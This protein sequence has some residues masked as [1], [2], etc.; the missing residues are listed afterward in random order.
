MRANRTLPYV[1][2]VHGIEGFA[3]QCGWIPNTSSSQP[4]LL[5]FEDYFSVENG[6]F[7]L[8]ILYLGGIN[9]KNIV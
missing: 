7:N 8:C 1:D 2:E 6:H 5:P 3:I 9:V 4:E